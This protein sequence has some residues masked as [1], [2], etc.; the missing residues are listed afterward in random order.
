MGK[1]PA[2]IGKRIRENLKGPW[3]EVVGVVS[4]ERD[5]GVN[6]K[7]PTTVFWPILMTNFSKATRRSCHA[8]LPT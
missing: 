4:D 3:R 1:P 6:K 2:A 7:A 5:D 8:P